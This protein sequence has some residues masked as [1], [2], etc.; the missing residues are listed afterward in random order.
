MPRTRLRSGKSVRTRAAHSSTSVVGVRGTAR[1][2]Q[3]SSLQKTPRCASVAS[4]STWPPSAS[5]RPSASMGPQ[6]AALRA[7]R[8]KLRFRRFSAPTPAP[9]R[10]G[11]CSRPARRPR[12][13]RSTHETRRRGAR[14]RAAAR[15]CNPGPATRGRARGRR[16]CGRRARRGRSRRRAGRCR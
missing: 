13:R 4:T 3:R 11:R 16:G 10:C 1:G 15:R 8:K 2:T 7:P 5:S 12:D 6:T 9:A 14:A